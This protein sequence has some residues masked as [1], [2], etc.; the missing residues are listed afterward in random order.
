MDKSISFK[1]AMLSGKFRE[2]GKYVKPRS[3]SGIAEA[4]G[5]APDHNAQSIL[6]H[7][8]KPT[9]DAILIGDARYTLADLCDK[10]GINLDNILAE[11]KSDDKIEELKTW[12]RQRSSHLYSLIDSFPGLVNVISRGYSKKFK[13]GAT[14][15]NYPNKK[16]YIYYPDCKDGN[17]KSITMN[18]SGD[19]RPY[20]SFSPWNFTTDDFK[21]GDECVIC[22]SPKGALVFLLAG[23]KFVCGLPGDGKLAAYHADFLLTKTKKFIIVTDC[24][25]SERKSAMDM[26]KRLKTAGA[27]TV[28]YCDPD[29]ERNDGYDETDVLRDKG[30]SGL[31][32]MLSS[33]VLLKSGID[34]TEISNTISGAGYFTADGFRETQ[35]GNSKRFLAQHGK[36]FFYCEKIK[37]W[38]FWDKH[39]W[40]ADQIS[41][42]VKLAMSSIES[43][44]EVVDS[45]EDDKKYSF[46]NFIKGSSNANHVNGVIRLS[47][48]ECTVE[49][50]EL[51]K[52][53]YLCGVQNGVLDLKSGLLVDSDPEEYITRRFNAVYDNRADCKEWFNFL[54]MI[55]KPDEIA[56]LQMILGYCLSGNVREK[57]FFIMH[58]T[59]NNGKSTFINT[60]LNIVGDYGKQIAIETFLKNN[61]KAIRNDLACLDKVRLACASEVERG[62]KFAESLMKN[63]SGGKGKLAARFLYGEYFDFQ[64]ECKVVFDTN[65]APEVTAGG[66]AFWSRVKM[67]PFLAEITEKDIKAKPNIDEI[68]MSEASGILNW[69]VEGFMK[70]DLGELTTPES[71]FLSVQ[72]YKQDYDP[73]ELFLKSCFD[74]D[75]ENFVYS[76]HVI[77]AYKAWAKREGYKGIRLNPQ[78]LRGLMTS[79]RYKG[80]RKNTG[81][82]YLGLSLKNEYSEVDVNDNFGCFD[83][84]NSASFSSEQDIKGYSEG[85]EG[86]EGYKSDGSHAPT[87]APA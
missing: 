48:T 85:S 52:N 47:Q 18:G 67:I 74:F 7:A 49:H 32:D 8:N 51:D 34:T 39:W 37:T 44:W 53:I 36:K 80:H 40:R 54:D 66:S 61:D 59:G 75:E 15:F 46:V 79:R 87:R 43:L 26:G 11:Y 27:E 60:I 83:S 69:L 56:Y 28:L 77:K 68:L 84:D 41:Y 21:N 72:E 35:F 10:L 9:T 45:V 57:S 24:K 33:P 5:H 73:M 16:S 1:I 70:W 31:R 86:T 22:D 19:R 25:P 3:D 65:F 6:L 78:S 76:M 23:A 81:N 62:G 12:M 20:K 42:V 14:Y 58:G 82:G 55:Q 50:S 29:P 71:V 4:F 64:P 30:I 38:F 2:D 13:C 63:I 17:G